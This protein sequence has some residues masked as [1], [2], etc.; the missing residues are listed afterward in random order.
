MDEQ[1]LSSK[2]ISGGG[3][4]DGLA[5][6][7]R[8]NALDLDTC[9]R[10]ADD[11]YTDEGGSEFGNMGAHLEKIVSDRL[12]RVEE[13]DGKLY[14]GTETNDL[15]ALDEI[16]DDIEFK[17]L[18]VSTQFI[19]TYTQS[20]KRKTLFLSDRIES[21]NVLKSVAESYSAG[22]HQFTN[23]LMR[24]ELKKF[25]E[26]VGAYDTDRPFS[27]KVK[28]ILQHILMVSQAINNFRE[29]GN[30]SLKQRLQ[31]R[32]FYRG[33]DMSKALSSRLEVGTLFSERGFINT[34]E[35]LE[36]AERCVQF[37]ENT[38]P[39]IFKFETLDA[40]SA[41]PFSIFLSEKS[42]VVMPT[43]FEIIAIKKNY[44]LEN[45]QIHIVECRDMN[46]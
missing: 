15:I 26:R 41:D 24:G 44:G 4:H 28:D 18:T 11:K 7:H 20:V 13:A 12:F 27:K 5:K 30:T 19:E 46:R 42:W 3:S 17:S 14:V 1:Q 40:V 9:E 33:D 23:C 34:S 45:R 10:Y 38:V 39:V 31:P 29:S 8:G 6:I 16:I 32:F 36:D 21:F 22:L 43:N 37:E 2:E 35:S 25:R